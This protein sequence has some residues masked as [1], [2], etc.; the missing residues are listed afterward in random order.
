M[1]P[2][3]NSHT[4]TLSPELL[5]ECCQNQTPATLILPDP[6]RSFQ[7][8]FLAGFDHLV[9]FEFLSSLEK[10]IA[11]DSVGCVHF[12]SG[13]VLHSLFCR[14]EKVTERQITVAVLAYAV[15]NRRREFRFRVSRYSDLRVFALHGKSDRIPV[16]L[17]DIS[18]T[19][20]GIRV[21]P[22]DRRNWATGDLI[23]LEIHLH[24]IQCRISASI[25]RLELLTGLEFLSSV[26]G[27]QPGFE[28]FRKI[29]SEL[30]RRYLRNRIRD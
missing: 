3:L 20:A 15:G 24:Q 28:D 14:L 6:I 17:V 8:K 4:L 10:K 2:P 30:E 16:T 19:G 27:G 13:D 9:R 1:E 11:S 25:I 7:V 21:A 5:S 18:R 12:H 26:A 29:F 22:G 23:E